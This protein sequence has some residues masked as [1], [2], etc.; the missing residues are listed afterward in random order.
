MSSLFFK[1]LVWEINHLV[2]KTQSIRR[3][4]RRN[5]GGGGGE[6]KEYCNIAKL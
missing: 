1:A 3:L 6:E 2:N 4:H 5:G